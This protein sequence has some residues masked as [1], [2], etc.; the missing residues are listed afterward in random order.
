MTGTE[1]ARAVSEPWREPTRALP[2][3]W[4]AYAP[5]YIA[6]VVLILGG[7]IVV[8]P[9]SVY[10]GYLFVIG[11]SAHVLGWLIIPS[12]GSR[13]AWVALPS[14]LCACALLIGSAGTFALILPLLGWLFVRQRPA[15][16]YLVLV[17]PIVSA[18]VLVTLYPQYGDG[19][20]VAFVSFVVIVGSAWLGLVIARSRPGR[21]AAR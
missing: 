14:T 5:R 21:S 19:D 12:R 6:A 2:L 8:Q 15:L 17:L 11:A 10:A 20:I 16:S 18:F 1:G 3:R 13:R 9:T 4:G 7:A